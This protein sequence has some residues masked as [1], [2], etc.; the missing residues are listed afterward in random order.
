MS[1]VDHQRDSPFLELVA[2]ISYYSDEPGLPESPLALAQLG[3]RLAN[4]AGRPNRAF[5]KVV[6]AKVRHLKE[7]LKT[8]GL[9]LQP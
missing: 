1:V 8:M 2:D 3:E 7:I 4:F 6:N 9:T 5:R